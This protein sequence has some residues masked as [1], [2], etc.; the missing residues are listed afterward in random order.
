MQ[1]QYFSLSPMAGQESFNTMEIRPPN[2]MAHTPTT[3]S[4]LAALQHDSF[5]AGSLDGSSGF[6]S[7][8]YG[9]LSYMDTSAPQ[10]VSFTDFGSS[11]SFDV[12][13]FT[14]QDLG[15]TSNGAPAESE[16]DHESE[17]KPEA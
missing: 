11:S 1:Q 14:P 10:D 17:V 13:S 6:N 12:A 5:P 4:M 3:S 8:A 16:P 15:M 9:A 7:D 2:A